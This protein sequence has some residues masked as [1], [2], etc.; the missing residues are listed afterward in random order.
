MKQHEKM[1]KTML[2]SLFLLLMLFSY[3]GSILAAGDIT[4]KLSAPANVSKGKPFK[5]SYILNNAQGQSINV[6][7]KISGFNVIYGPG[8]S[9]SSASSSLN[10]RT[11]QQIYTETYTYTLI[12]EKEG[13]FTIPA[14]TIVAGGKAY[15]SNTA[16]VKVLPPDK[17]ASSSQE[18]YS[19]PVT[20]PDAVKDNDI[21]VR[22]IPSKVKIY[23][24]EAFIIT[25][26]L[27]SSLDIERFVDIE[28][29]EFEG[30]IR[31]DIPM[32]SALQTRI[33]RI[34][35]KNYFS[36]DLVKYL[37]FPQRSGK[38]TIP[39]GK[40]SFIL[41][42]RSGRQVRTFLGPQNL[43]TSVQKNIVINPVILDVKSLPDGKP[44]NFANAVGNFNV[45]SQISAT[46]LKAN[47]GV[48]LT[49]DING[50][51][52]LKL[53][54]NPDI[55]LPS[56][57]EAYDPKVT[58]DVNP[59]N[60]GLAGSKKIEYFFI[61]RH[62]GKY[63]IPATQFSYFDPGSG[64]YKQLEIPAYTLN[65]AKD[66]T[67]GAGAATSYNNQS[68][69]KVAK[70]IRYIKDGTYRFSRTNDFMAGSLAYWLWYIIPT[71][72]FASFFIYYRKQI[73]ENAD[74]V[75]MKTKKANKVAIRRLQQADAFLKA[76]NKE[77]FY[78]EILRA[79]WG[80]LSD[81]L[82]IPVSNLNRENIEVELAKYG[83]GNDLIASF[84][85]I[86]DTCE[87]ARYA[88]NQE[89]KVMDNFYNEAIDTIT[90]M[91]NT[92]KLNKH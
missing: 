25:F 86:L 50:A 19:E 52:N 67:G 18:Y 15:K 51:G 10:G 85:S 65:V 82:V 1:Q 46:N 90:K 42:V 9:R 58:N 8:I 53:I 27:Y 29:P 73:R 33:E 34:N 12:A 41:R 47:D 71:L 28:F 2:R 44:A 4:L 21:F 20:Q 59:T 3:T 77:K 17:K 24:Q 26:K 83:A 23:E 81:K 16:R 75:R 43:M 56:D 36:A 66:P 48:T 7:D 35:G 22:A 40:A 74:I 57:F 68:D 11:V 37:L 13:T 45:K 80:Y 91:E 88:P 54:K 70:D 38:I 31:E 32:P 84:I 72:L 87:Y 92:I 62:E 76:N 55:K 49:V 69:V 30:F 39:A 60:S 64:T 6:S 78:E 89:Y 14:A 63:E 61:P 79:V 5:I